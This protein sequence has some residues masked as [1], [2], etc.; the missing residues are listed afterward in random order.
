MITDLNF[1]G[2]LFFF[3]FWSSTKRKR[4]R[5]NT[6]PAAQLFTERQRSGN[7]ATVVCSETAYSGWVTCWKKKNPKLSVLTRRETLLR[8]LP[9]ISSFIIPQIP[10]GCLQ[11]ETAT[12]MLNTEA[13]VR[14]VSSY[15]P[16]QSDFAV[17]IRALVCLVEYEEHLLKC[18]QMMDNIGTIQAVLLW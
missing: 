18:T 12:S 13:G 15:A 8:S 1:G 17:F 3:A 10:E 5:V 11:H 16:F 7:K 4:E 6:Q 14:S 9:E 2:F